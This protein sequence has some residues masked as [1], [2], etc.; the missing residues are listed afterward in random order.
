MS[1]DNVIT[2]SDRATGYTLSTCYQAMNRKVVSVIH[3]S[4]HLA[5]LRN[6]SITPASAV[7]NQPR[8]APSMVCFSGRRE[9]LVKAAS[10]ARRCSASLAS[11]TPED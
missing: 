1:L 4:K 10:A 9:E 3:N 11:G 8:V 2:S 5:R 6:T 7:R